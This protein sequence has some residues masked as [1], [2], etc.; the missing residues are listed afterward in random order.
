[1]EAPVRFARTVIRFGV[2]EL[3]LFS[4]ELYKR[5][6]RI[7]LQDQPFHILAVLLEQPGQLVTREELRQRLWPGE[8]VVSFD[9]GLNA[10]IRRLRF[11]LSDSAERPK[12][13]ETLPRRGYRFIGHVENG[14]GGEP[15]FGA[16]AVSPN[17]HGGSVELAAATPTMS[18][19][20][21]RFRPRLVSRSAMSVVGV[22]CVLTVMTAA[23]VRL[24]KSG[25]AKTK[26]LETNFA[27][28]TKASGAELNPTLSP[29]GKWIA[30]V[31]QER[32][33]QDI[34][35]Q[36]VGS[37]AHS[38]LTKD[39][40]EDDHQPAFSPDGR[41]IAFR[42]ER[43][44]GGIFVMTVRGS[45]VRR[46]SDFGFDPAWSPDGKDLVVATEGIVNALSR[47]STSVLWRINIATGR[48]RR[49][50][51]GD[52]VQPSWS[53][54]GQRIAFWRT[55]R[56]GGRRDIATVSAEG[57]AAIAVT[58]DAAFDWSPVWSPDGKY[59]YFSSDRGG[60][61]NLWRI[62]VDEQ[63]GRSVGEPEAITTPARWS[64][65]LSVG[66]GGRE[67]A[68]TAADPQSNIVRVSFDAQQEK[69]SGAPIPVTHGTVS[70]IQPVVS[71]DG[72]WI[73]YRTEAEQEDL[74]LSRVDGSEQ[75]KLTDDPAKDR[76]PSW[77]PDGKRIAFYSD[78]GGKYEAWVI[79]RDGSG[80]QQSTSSATRP[81]FFPLF[82]PD[83]R[84]IIVNSTD[85]SFTVPLS[86]KGP[87]TAIEP[88]P[89][90]PE[91]GRVFRASSLS[92]D[93]AWLAGTLYSVEGTRIPGV[94]IY[95]MKD[96][97]YRV[98]T[99]FG[100]WPSWLSDG[101][102]LV[103]G[104]KNG[105]YL[106]NR[107]SGSI[108]EILSVDGQ[109]PFGVSVSPTDNEIYFAHATHESDIWLLTMK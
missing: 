15:S 74:Y 85:G 53:P 107:V 28:V 41:L 94:A 2:F 93:G 12:F 26:S 48:K 72:E 71:P 100:A 9:D 105:L 47:T 1:M 7:K 82:F 97:R 56:N 40:A 79:N 44:G 60:S 39:S 81:I 80:L 106:A 35:L 38:N 83:A 30:Y 29:D 25:S 75:R 33:D 78:R 98:L 23:V 20:L 31:A 34:Y 87:A 46:V 51:E 57:G 14:T 92:R 6:H 13:I 62:A 21:S 24:V 45:A 103:F 10:A 73:V 70:V 90:Y 43:Q 3:D 63:S 58:N 66:A 86:G 104:D 89:R 27:H 11:A 102:R 32:G 8:T 37:D 5:G 16:H 4:R 108:R 22:L 18:L 65:D 96:R 76:G 91:T 59:L 19:E 99:A 36:R 17:A 68:F 67:I 88:L 61:M 84:Q 50:V 54:H 95:S 49:I 52:A 69:V 42:S 64:G 77:S 109:I 101:R 55:I